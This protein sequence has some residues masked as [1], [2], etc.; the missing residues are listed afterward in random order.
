MSMSRNDTW[1]DSAA[2]SLPGLTLKTSRYGCPPGAEP[3]SADRFESYSTPACRFRSVEAL[4]AH[5][6]GNGKFVEVL[7]I[8]N[9]VRT[10]ERKPASPGMPE[11]DL[12]EELSLVPDKAGKAAA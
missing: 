2:A 9:G 7:D 10:R 3:L 5:R 6:R 1:Y 4:R 8:L 11:W 12:V